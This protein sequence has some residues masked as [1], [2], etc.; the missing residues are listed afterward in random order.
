[1]KHILIFLI[2]IATNIT[3]FAEDLSTPP[4]KPVYKEIEFNGAKIFYKAAGQGEPLIVIH[5]GPGLSQDY[6]LPQM[7]E[8]EKTHFVIFYD[9]RGCGQSTG[10]ITSETIN[11][12]SFI[13][14]LDA[15][16]NAFHFEKVSILGHSWGGLLA[17]HYAITHPEHIKKLILSN[18][19]PASSEDWTLFMNEWVKRT[20]PYQTELA[21]IHNEPGYPEGDP[22]VIAR[23]Y[24]IVFKTYCYI[25]EK[26]NLINLRMSQSSC[27]NGAK[28]YEFLRK[29]VL[30]KPFN[31]YPLLTQL[32][33]DTLI[34][35]GDSDP[36]PLI[37]AQRIHEGIAGSKYVVI[38]NCGHFPY[39]ED[40][41]TYFKTINEF[42]Y[43]KEISNLKSN[44]IK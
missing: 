18:S 20:K 4:Q 42:L 41:N 16:R 43:E 34:L 31:L 44:H 38:K 8:L 2:A 32:K 26:A 22:D 19:A 28:V 3:S 25:P 23:F 6:L 12:E 21:A 35:H 33:V 37:T 40:P 17:M 36:V 29:N 1:M 24:R 27:Q 13:A 7:S 39:I 5:G 11:I 30:S 14:D 9:Q 15:V 10:E